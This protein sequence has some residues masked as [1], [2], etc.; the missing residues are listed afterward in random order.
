MSTNARETLRGFRD[1]KKIMT[2]ALKVVMVASLCA[3]FAIGTTYVVFAASSVGDAA[4]RSEDNVFTA[5]TNWFK[6]GIKIG[7]Q[8]TGGVT[9]YNGTIINN[10]TDANGNDNPVTIG[11]KL[12]VDDLLYR[13]E[14]GGTYPL[15]IADS[16]VPY[17]DASYSLGTTT[18]KWKDLYLSGQA[19]QSRSSFGL[20]KAAATIDS[21]GT[22]IRSVENIVDGDHAVSVTSSLAGV[23]VVNFNFTVADRYIVVTPRNA[24]AGVMPVASCSISGETVTV[25]IMNGKA[26]TLVANDFDIVVF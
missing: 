24:A 10:T 6:K 8:G 1:K 3:A 22:V 21:K 12:R 7:E 23:Y 16:M 15:K 14:I 2:K 4:S 13:M 20:A 5:I 17:R 9:Y 19:S 11:D 26:D 18:Y 25:T